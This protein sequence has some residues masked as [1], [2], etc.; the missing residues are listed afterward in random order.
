MVLTFFIWAFEAITALAI[1]GAV[2]AIAVFAGLAVWL[3]PPSKNQA[4]AESDLKPIYAV[5]DT[6]KPNGG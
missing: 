1:S 5:D 3:H 6:A 4:T 2:T